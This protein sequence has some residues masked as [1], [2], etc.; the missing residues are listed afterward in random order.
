MLFFLWKFHV[1][2]QGNITKAFWQIPCVWVRRIGWIWYVEFDWLGL[3]RLIF[4]PW[5]TVIRLSRLPVGRI[6]EAVPT[7]P[8]MERLKR[9]G[10][11]HVHPVT[12]NKLGLACALE[13][14]LKSNVFEFFR[15]K[16]CSTLVKILEVNGGWGWMR[17]RMR[18][19]EDDVTHPGAR[20]LPLMLTC[21]W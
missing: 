7:M 12:N 10:N 8:L 20:S 1:L 17:V 14:P 21:N 15:V 19:D 2:L 13:W 9:V 6:W 18:M 16:M 11:L 3:W 4:R 5:P